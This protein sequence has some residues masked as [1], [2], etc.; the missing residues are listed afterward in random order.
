MA[1]DDTKRIRLGTTPNDGN[2]E[3]LRSAGGKIN[4]NFEELYGLI[5]AGG[6]VTLVNSITAGSGISVSAASGDV[7]VT[8][9]APYVN[10]FTAL[11][12]LGQPSVL[13][14]SSQVLTL[15]AGTNMT[16]TTSGNSVTINAANQQ[17]AN[18]NASS[19]PTAILNKP[20]IPAAQLQSDWSQTNNAVLDYIKNK[21]TDL[22][23]FTDSTNLLGRDSYITT[24][25][26]TATIAPSASVII[27]SGAVSQLTVAVKATII[28]SGLRGS[29]DL[30]T[31]ACEMMIVRLLPQS[32]VST[33]ESVVYGT[34]YTGGVALAS[35]SAQWNAGTDSVEI[36]ATNL[37]SVTGDVLQA[38][39]VATQF[40]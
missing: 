12:V 16:L 30:Q 18:W 29:S 36:V 21:P 19:G 10:S 38:K 14:A 1:F 2:G 13:A 7:V 27:Y 5:G 8:N 9:S 33:V 40:L 37:S 26:T 11:A 35:F 39:V 23:N 24:T 31:H 20:S 28:V 32:G 17:Q 6:E 3:T 4:S 25:Q 15:V 22:I 34:I